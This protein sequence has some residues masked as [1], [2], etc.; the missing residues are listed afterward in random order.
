MSPPQRAQQPLPLAQAVAAA[1]QRAAPAHAAPAPA[2]PKSLDDLFMKTRAKPCL[3]Y[4]P[5]SEAEARCCLVPRV[6]RV[7]SSSTG[8]C[9]TVRVGSK[10]RSF[11]LTRLAWR[12]WLRQLR[13]RD[14]LRG[15]RAPAA[16]R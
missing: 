5:V 15:Q 4:L 9:C 8:G 6:A 2:E 12:C 11:L 7:I 16:H 13:R 3:Y 1:A 10:V 14:E